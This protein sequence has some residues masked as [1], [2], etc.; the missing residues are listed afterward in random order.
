MD[1]WLDLEGWLD[2]AVAE[3]RSWLGS[4]GPFPRHPALDVD[5]DRL[6]GALAELSDRMLDNYPFGHPRY[7]GQMVKPP[8]PVAVVGYLA[9]MQ[10]NP[11]NHALDGGPATSRPA[12]TS[13]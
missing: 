8:H 10:L 11:N 4:F 3:H 1:L 13:G 7:A 2:R 5:P 6:A 9:A 12:V